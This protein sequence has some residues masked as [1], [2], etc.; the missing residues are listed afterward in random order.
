[1]DALDGNAIAGPLFNY[2]GTEMT[3]ATGSC[4]HCGASAQIAE[5]RVYARVPGTVV[6]CHRC[7]QVV[8][9]IIDIRDHLRVDTRHFQ[10]DP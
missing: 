10:L 6:R 4:R 3:T 9:V 7:G 2:F 1:M 5:L 8:M